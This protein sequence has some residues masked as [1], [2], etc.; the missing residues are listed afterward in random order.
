MVVKSGTQILTGLS[1]LPVYSVSQGAVVSP[2]N[3]YVQEG[4]VATSLNF[5]A[6][7]YVF[8]L[9]LLRCSR[10]RSDFPSMGPDREGITYTSETACLSEAGY[11]YHMLNNIVEVRQPAPPRA[12]RIQTGYFAGP[13]DHQG[14]KGAYGRA[15]FGLKRKTVSLRVVIVGCWRPIWFLVSKQ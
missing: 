11:C 14:K 8:V 7:L 12:N 10:N 3:I 9:T 15:W 1:Q 13:F 5:H 6:E 4:D 2:V